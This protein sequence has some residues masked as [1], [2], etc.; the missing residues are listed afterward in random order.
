MP[1]FIV[2]TIDIITV[3]PYVRGSCRVS[4]HYFHFDYY[5]FTWF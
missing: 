1:E 4:L 5:Y 2:S 3:I